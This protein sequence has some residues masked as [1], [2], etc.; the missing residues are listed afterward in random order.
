MKVV[1]NGT[2]GANNEN[3]ENEEED[4]HMLASLVEENQV[5]IKTTIFILYSFDL[6]GD[7]A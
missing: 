1:K 4:E 6:F 2:E 7:A 5:I 3:N